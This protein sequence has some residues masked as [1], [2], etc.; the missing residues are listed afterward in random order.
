MNL[1]Y[2]SILLLAGLVILLAIS[3]YCNYFLVK[4]YRHAYRELSRVTLDPLGLEQAQAETEAARGL[5]E[6]PLVLFYGDSRAAAWPAPDAAAPFV[7]VNLGVNGQTAAQAALRYQADA[8]LLHPDVVVLQVGI[9]DLRVIPA[10]GQGAQAVITATEANIQ[11][12]VAQATAGGATV[13]LTTIF[14]VQNPPWQDRMFW[15]KEV[16]TAVTAVNQFIP[17]LAGENVLV[18]DASIL[19]ADD[20]GELQN[21]YAADYLHLNA[22]GYLQLNDSLL[23][24]LAQL[25]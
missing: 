9:N 17:S 20:K 1:A 16:M 25:S 11:E 6:G 12:I 22:A 24:F 18:L 21:K 3:L 2:R 19:L 10:V 23:T 5:K 14:P 15:S 13:V 4:R 8:A 7:F